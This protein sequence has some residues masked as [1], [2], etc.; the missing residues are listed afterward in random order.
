MPN[1]S[2]NDLTYQKLIEILCATSNPEHMQQI[3]DAITTP[4]ERKDFVNRLR[5]FDLLQKKR[6]QREI[7]ERLGVGI[8]TVSRGAKAYQQFDAD[9]LFGL[10]ADNRDA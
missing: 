5:I 6:P 10:L 7:S 8:A 1:A 9:G 2:E 3:L 4:K